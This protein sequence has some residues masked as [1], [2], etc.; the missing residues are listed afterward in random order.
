VTEKLTL[1]VILKHV[2]ESKVI[3]SSQHRFTKAKPRLINLIAFYDRMT[4]WEDEGKA[5]ETAYIGFSEVFDIVLPNI[6][7]DKIRK[8]GLNEWILHNML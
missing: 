4:S 7:I 1:D 5:V 8:C 2:E 6:L 3:R